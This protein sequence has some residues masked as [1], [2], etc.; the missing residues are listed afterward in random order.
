M[1]RFA[2]ALA[3]LAGCG[4]SPPPPPPGPASITVARLPV[5]GWDG[6]TAS[7]AAP[8]SAAGR[9][10]AFRDYP[11][12]R[13]A[14]RDFQNSRFLDRVDG[15]P[16]PRAAALRGTPSFRE[17]PI[18]VTY[19]LILRGSD[20]AERVALA[21]AVDP[22]QVCR[23]AFDDGDRAA[24][25]LVPPELR[26]PEPE[27]A[28][29]EALR[30]PP[31]LTV[32]HDGHPESEA[33]ARALRAVLRRSA[34]EVVLAGEETAAAGIFRLEARS[35]DVAAFV[36][37]LKP[38]AD[39]DPTLSVL[40]DS[41]EHASPAEREPWIAAVEQSLLDG[42]L[43]VPLARG[44]IYSLAREGCPLALDEFGR[45]VERTNPAR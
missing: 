16:A 26:L 18:A 7:G 17:T 32:R 21:A 14:E 42:A 25:R 3:L 2:L 11:D 9:R 27:L 12:P 8:A 5:S 15:L 44:R 29:R 34:V 38:Y 31:K 40:F 30:P 4:K 24:R 28:P 19:A 35:P 43:I 10:V 23:E 45:Y 20:R 1:R 33:L 37:A 6:R 22:A 13:L 39:S 41:L 36:S